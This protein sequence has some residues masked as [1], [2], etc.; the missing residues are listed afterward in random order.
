M[1]SVYLPVEL[2]YPLIWMKY[3]DPD[4][5]SADTEKFAPAF[6]SQSPATLFLLTSN[7]M[8]HGFNVVD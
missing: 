8:M 7:T 5:A 4:L 6:P 1:V 2:E 3:V